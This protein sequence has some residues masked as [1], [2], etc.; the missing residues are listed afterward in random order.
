MEKIAEFHFV[1][2]PAFHAAAR[3]NCGKKLSDGDIQRA[4]DGL[5]RPVR[6]TSGSAGYDFRTPFALHLFPGES[7]VIPTGIRVRMDGGWWLGL[8]PR[9]GLGYQW[10]MQLANTLGVIDGDYFHAE[11]EG[12]I[13]I[14]ISLPHGDRP[15]PELVLH[16]GDKFAQGIFLPY[17]ITTDD[18][19]GGVRVG[20]FGS[21]GQ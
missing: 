3:E 9:S 14:K 12:H 10:H 4:Y 8:L 1:S 16:P 17:G 2:Y 11:N 5:Q 6:A 20:G 18:T 19:A 15:S 13:M 7:G 21:T